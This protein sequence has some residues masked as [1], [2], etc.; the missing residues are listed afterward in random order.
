[1]VNCY[2]HFT[3]VSSVNNY[4]FVVFCEPDIK[5]DGRVRWGQGVVEYVVLFSN[6]SHLEKSSAKDI[7]ELVVELYAILVPRRN[8]ILIVG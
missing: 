6:L 4:E 5:F 7:A 2:W 8:Y 1:M 3:M